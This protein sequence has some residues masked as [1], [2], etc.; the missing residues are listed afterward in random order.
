MAVLSHSDSSRTG[1]RLSLGFSRTKGIKALKTIPSNRIPEGLAFLQLLE[2]HQD[3]CAGESSINV[4]KLDRSVPNTIESIGTLLSLLDRL[5]SCFWGCRGGHHVVEHL[6]G[7][8]VSLAAATLPLINM[9]HY[10]EGWALTRSVAEIGNLMWLFFIA[11]DE[12]NHWATSSV[13]ERRSRFAPFV[14]RRTIE[15][16]GSVVPHDQDA[17]STMC[18]VGVH[19]NPT[20]PPHA[21]HNLHGVPTLG[22]I[23]QE[24]GFI[25]SLAKLGWAVASVGGP[26]ARMADI[27]T[28]HES[29]IVDIVGTLVAELPSI[30]RDEVTDSSESL[31]TRTEW[32]DRNL[33]AKE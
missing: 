15:A 10:D 25:E 17:Y 26:A 16:T 8:S 4:H 33:R 28:I 27:S 20:H 6:T 12:L 32:L 22:G 2:R 19:P 24:L 18:E 31:L 3:D 11:S 14:V 7:R 21:S 30:S 29:R 9:G 5:A 13:K 23:Y 1:Q